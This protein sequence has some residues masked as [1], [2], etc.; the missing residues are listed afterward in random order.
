MAEIAI[1][2]AGE[3]CLNCHQV[4][5]H[6]DTCGEYALKR[7]LLARDAMIDVGYFRESEVGIDVAPRISELAM[8]VLDG[9]W[10]PPITISPELLDRAIAAADQSTDTEL[11]GLLQDRR[12]ERTAT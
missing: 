3:K 8:A 10:P 6:A 11:V 12:Y 4:V 2:P 9:K 1:P 7:L 5:A